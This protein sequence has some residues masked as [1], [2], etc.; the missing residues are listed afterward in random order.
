MEE[1]K[2]NGGKMTVTT[3][4]RSVKTGLP[5]GSLVH[6][7]EETGEA[8]GIKL[9]EYNED[10]FHEADCTDI[11]ECRPV[12]DGKV[13]N[14]LSI[15]GIHR[16]DIIEAVGEVFGLHPLLLEDVMNT[17]QR[18]KFEDYG[19]YV[20]VVVKRLEVDGPVRAIEAEQISLVLG[21]GYVV[22][23]GERAEDAFGVIRERIK[24]GKGRLRKMGSDYL[25]YTLVD[26]IVDNYFSVMEKLGENI[27]IVEEAVVTRPEV[28]V[29]RSIHNLK[30]EMIFLRRSVWPM[31]EVV[32]SLEREETCLVTDQASVY[33]RDVYD[34]VVQVMDSIDT[35][36][37]ML[38]GM[39]DIYLSS[40]SNKLNEVMKVLTI[41]ATIFIPLTFIVGLYG[42]NF[43]YMP[44]LKLVW[45]YP[46]VLL[47][48]A[49]VSAFMVLYFKRKKWF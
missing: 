38:S 5:P 21:D 36:R 40:V 25:L 35:Y 7:G 4:K 1:A 22:T 49:V 28:P 42:M 3:R 6:V 33:F 32:G 15:N 8:V 29:L 11:R 39:L 24:T 10:H 13:I 34:H 37:D 43:Q 2:Q 9:V 47:V 23:F 48:M 26:T 41:I 12:R 16:A 27:E 17:N 19:D 14:W 30:R 45:G 46:A 31:R 18:P 20:F 44:E